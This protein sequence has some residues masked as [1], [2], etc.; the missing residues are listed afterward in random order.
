MGVSSQR[1]AP[2]RSRFTPGEG[3]PVPIVHEAGWAPEPVW[4]QEA[5]GEI[6][7]PLPGNEPI[8]PYIDWAT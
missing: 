6:L 7:L 4:T 5:R 2:P 1:H 3:P 8:S